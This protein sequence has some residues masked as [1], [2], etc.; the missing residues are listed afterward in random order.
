[1]VKH[2]VI[3][4]LKPECKA[5]AEANIAKIKGLLEGLVG[6]VPGLAKLEVAK[7]IRDGYDFGLYSEL[8]SREALEGYTVHP[9]HQQAAAFVRSV[10]CDRA[11][12][13]FE[14]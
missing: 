6:V 1:M 14:V 8:V 12:L 13:D 2:I 11:S 4:N 5:N 7:N 3:W 9:A 10:V